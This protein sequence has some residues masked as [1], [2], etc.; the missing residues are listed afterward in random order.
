M[1][2]LRLA[3]PMLCTVAIAACAPSNEEG[4]GGRS[5]IGYELAMARSAPGTVGATAEPRIVDLTPRQLIERMMGGD[6]RLIDVRTD[7]EVATGMIPGAEHI[8][9]D[10]FD[11]AALRQDENREVILYCRSGRRSGIAAERLASHTGR[12][13][14]HLAGGILAWQESGNP[15]E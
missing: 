2:R 12:P 13:V 3:L 6:I 15:V 1:T 7:E 4:D 8:A 9:L 5:P 10:E 11:P 14:A